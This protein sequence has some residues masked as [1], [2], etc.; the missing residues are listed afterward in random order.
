[1]RGLAESYGSNYFGYSG[2]SVK[3]NG[4]GAYKI[5]FNPPFKDMPAVT[6]T[7]HEYLSETYDFIA[8]VRSVEKG[9]VLVFTTRNG[10]LK[11]CAF[12]IIAIGAD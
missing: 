3:K 8:N 10:R 2:W 4:E 7:P 9:S 1:V 6:V 5:T 12:H 11:D